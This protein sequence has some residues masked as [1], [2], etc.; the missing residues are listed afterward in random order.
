[1]LTR[2]RG[3][4][5]IFSRSEWASRLLGLS[6]FTGSDV[7]SGLVMIQ[8]D[9]LS[10]TQF[11]RALKE[12]R[13]PFLKSLL[14]HQGY[15]ARPLYSGL[16]SATP[17]IQGELFYGVKGCVPSFSFLDRASG[18][19]QKMYDTASVKQVERRL[20]AQGEGLLK[21]GSAYADI[22]TGGAQERHFCAG[23]RG[24]RG[25]FWAAHPI[26]L[27]FII[28]LYV[29][30]LLRATVLMAWEMMVSFYEAVRGTFRGQLL[31]EELKFILVRLSVCVLL[32]ELVVTGVKIDIAR[33]LPVI[34]LNFFGYDEQSH[35]RGPSSRFAH[36]TLM[37]IDRG[38]AKIWHA[39]H[40]S[41]R[42]S[43]DVWIY[44]DH[45]QEET[46]PYPVEHGRPIQQA[47]DE[48][49]S[50]EMPG[51]SQKA[52]V[53]GMGPIQHIYPPEPLPWEARERLARAFIDSA[54]IPMVLAAGTEGKAVAW[55]DHGTFTLPEE[56]AGVLGAQH[57]FLEETARDLT[58][59]CHHPDAGT[60]LL[61]GW[62]QGRPPKTFPSEN[63]S[64][65]GPG[66]EETRAFA[67]LPPDAPV[68]DASRSHLRPLSL[69]EGTL[70][71]LGRME[72]AP[73][74]PRGPAAEPSRIL[75]IMTYN[76]HSCVGMDGKLSP[77][78]IA[79]VIARHRPDAVAL[80]ELDVRHPRTGGVDQA[81]QIARRLAMEFH[82]HA[83][84]RVAE[85]LYGNALLSRFPMRL[86]RAAVLPAL[87]RRALLTEPRGALWVELDVE[88]A[89]LH[90]INAHLSLWPAER[91]IQ[92]EA[93]MGPDWVGS[94]EALGPMVVCGDFNA[95]PAS[96]VYRKFTETFRDAQLSL[97]GRFPK[98]TW[99]SRYPFTRIDHL[100]AG[101]GVE[102]LDIVVP[103][104]ELDQ[105]SSDHLPLL[106][107]L[108]ITVVRRPRGAAAT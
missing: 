69:R 18:K 45:G 72:P 68:D 2:L 4:R 42:R 92:A 13:L 5:R 61:S 57:P 20:S 9:G 15:H 41:S 87:K 83:S 21:G 11:E 94:P 52:L 40:R 55:T 12:G 103:R 80:Q 10:C 90:L 51:A 19:I 76:V 43:Y 56:A 23:D 35:R 64:H 91:A 6:R 70:R 100:F 54:G 105:I 65:A 46:T 73:R 50:R 49:F 86:M 98:A 93:L 17:G 1:M 26:R 8:V 97:P 16:P 104:T 95:A 106:A 89:S 44:S 81:E 24:W 78:R 39:A 14:D 107:E 102:V 38:V 32:R 75:R 30:V 25:I 77:E 33:G 66:F 34:H 67:L 36:W 58:A 59:L 3:L 48:I 88:G 60:L 28:L 101:P 27:P 74:S 62:R 47:V 84:Y 37:G 63:G 53:T 108:R 79:R 31:I 99:L 22:F 96:P 82:F 85:G 71:L 7:S 29:D